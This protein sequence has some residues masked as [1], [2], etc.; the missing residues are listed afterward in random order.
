VSF[1]SVL[2]RSAKF[3]LSLTEARGKIICLALY[4]SQWERKLWRER[5]RDSKKV[6]EKK[7]RA[8][9]A[10]KQDRMKAEERH[11]PTELSQEKFLE[12]TALR[13]SVLEWRN[14]ISPAARKKKG[15]KKGRKILIIVIK[16]NY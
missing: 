5:K 10:L 15:R 11:I 1:S 9:C 3:C 8:R 13:A 2:H 7:T 6:D 14:P 4:F 16:T 12:N